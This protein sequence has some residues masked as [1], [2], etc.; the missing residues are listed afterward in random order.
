MIQNGTF[1]YALHGWGMGLSLF[2]FIFLIWAV[3]YFSGN[4]SKKGL[5]AKET[6]DRR[7]AD[8][9]IDTDEYQ[10]RLKVLQSSNKEK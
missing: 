3:M 9:D 5:S 1:E 6:L 8:G 10:K 2:I 4:S 7:Y